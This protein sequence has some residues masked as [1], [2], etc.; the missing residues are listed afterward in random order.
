M[1]RNFIIIGL[2]YQSILPAYIIY[3]PT[4][5]AI[6]ASASLAAAPSRRILGVAL[7]KIL[8][9]VLLSGGREAFQAL[10]VCLHLGFKHLS[11]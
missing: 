9:P 4:E 11:Q 6:S 7:P 3:V 5:V 2:R 10:E 8:V 1:E